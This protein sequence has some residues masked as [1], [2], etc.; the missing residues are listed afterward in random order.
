MP[1]SVSALKMKF[2]FAATALSAAV[3]ASNCPADL[4]SKE[5]GKRLGPKLS[6]NAAILLPSSNEW[7]DVIERASYPR[8]NP[9]YKAVVEVA[10]EAD[11][12]ATVRFACPMLHCL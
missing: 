2:L 7:D 11:V 8:I 5:I 10:T 1:L 6:E 4:T 12:E 3:S 9:D